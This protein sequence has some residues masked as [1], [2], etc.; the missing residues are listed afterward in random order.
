MNNKFI[1]ELIGWYGAIAIIVAYFLN[2]FSLI[3]TSSIGY[4]FLN[5]TGAMGIIIVSFRKKDY[6]SMTLNIIWTMIGIIAL[7]RLILL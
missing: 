5:I 3:S 1:W 4:L 6:Q 2:S 7:I